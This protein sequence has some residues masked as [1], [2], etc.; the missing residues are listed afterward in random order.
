MK[1]RFESSIFK[2]I[3]YVV[4]GIFDRVFSAV[5]YW[6][7]KYGITVNTK[8]NKEAVIAADGWYE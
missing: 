7:K 3:E 6:F 1:L 5:Q 2:Y 4:I 8:D